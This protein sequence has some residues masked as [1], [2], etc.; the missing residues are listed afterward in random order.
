MQE[1][2]EDFVETD[3]RH[4]HVSHLFGVYPGKQITPDTP[5]FFSAARRA[6]ELRGDDG[7]GWS[8][9]W[10]INFW[11]RFQNGDHAFV[12][13]KNLLRPIGAS[14]EGTQITGGGVYP[15]LF[16]AHPPFQIDGNFG[17]TAGVCEMLVQS[18]R[19][20]VHLLPALPTAWPTGSVRGLRARGGVELDLTWRDG[21]LTSA[22]FRPQVSQTAKVRYGEKVIERQL[23]AGQPDTINREDITR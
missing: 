9:G 18:H 3:V 13:V 19:D 10:K 7:T 15:N 17:F 21:K 5:D 8:L 12:L 20:E 22:Q 2:F 1:W 23:A 16:D 4:R 6:L 11:A 14:V